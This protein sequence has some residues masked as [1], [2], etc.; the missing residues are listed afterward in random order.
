[1]KP[2]VI[3]LFGLPGSGKTSLAKSLVNPYNLINKDNII[4]EEFEK[5]NRPYSKDEVNKF[6]YG[7]L[8]KNKEYLIEKMLL[9]IDYSKINVMDAITTPHEATYLK[10]QEEI[11]F[12]LIG[13]WTPQEERIKRIVEKKRI[14][15]IGF[16]EPT[17]VDEF[18]KLDTRVARYFCEEEPNLFQ[19]ANQ[20]ISNS[21][22]FEELKQQFYN[23][24]K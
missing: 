16:D 19:I 18:Y 21:G 20:I 22:T 9:K 7:Q 6:I 4:K 24:I 13:I 3:G 12:K 5:T 2:T 14:Q 15:D 17:T 10:K 1:M 23:N 11:D 8:I